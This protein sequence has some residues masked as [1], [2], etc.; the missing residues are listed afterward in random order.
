MPM[1]IHPQLGRSL[2]DAGLLKVRCDGSC[3]Q[4]DEEGMKRF[5]PCTKSIKFLDGSQ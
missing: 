2:Y 3:I 1:R 4:N 5:C